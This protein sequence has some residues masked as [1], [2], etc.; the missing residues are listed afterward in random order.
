MKTK[1]KIVA[2]ILLAIF[3]LGAV[4]TSTYANHL[5][6]GEASTELSSINPG[7]QVVHYL[8]EKAYLNVKIVDDNRN[9]LEGHVVR[10][11]SSVNTDKI[12]VVTKGEV[13][14]A[15]GIVK[16][17]VTAGEP[18]LV[19]YSAYDLT[20]DVVLKNRAKVV[21]FN[22][23]AEIFTASKYSDFDDVSYAAL[24]NSAGPVD[25]FKFEDL[26]DEI[27]VGDEVTMKVSAYDE[28]DELVSAYEGEVRFSV[29]G[30][31]AKFADLPED[32]E[33]TTQDQGSH[34]FSLAFT[35]DQLGIYK[36]KVTDLENLAIYGEEE[37]V[38]TDSGSSGDFE[39]LDGIQLTTPI[40]GT[41]SSNVQVISGS[42]DPGIK[43][44]IFDNG[45][46]IGSVI[47]N[48]SGKFSFTT[49]L[50][51]DGEHKIYVASVNDVGTVVK[52]SKTVD[53]IIDTEAS[54]VSQVT[55]EP[56]G[57]VDPGTKMTVKVFAKEELS[58][59][60]VVVK[61][62]VYDLKRTGD[63]YQVSFNAPIEFGEYELKFVLVDELG[64][65]TEVKDVKFIKVGSLLGEKPQLLKVTG[66]VLTPGNNK[67]TLNW[68]APAPGS[69]IVKNYRVFYGTSPNQ[70]TQA[71]DTFTNAT[72]WYV[73]NLQNGTEYYFAVA[74]VDMQ[75]NV[76][77]NFDK[78][79]AA[80]P[81]PSVA[82]VPTPDIANG[83]GGSEALDEM[84]KDVSESG[85][86]MIWLLAV[87]ALGGFCYTIF[88]KEKVC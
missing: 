68:D 19:S 16:F 85:P 45:E 86:E 2:S 65:E 31:N 83:T 4:S 57:A 10:L 29:G 21:Y 27:A 46:E 54:S 88:K 41:Y 62:N 73:P 56:A 1:I 79:L 30:A 72:T 59:A 26:P 3:I 5:A 78:I 82:N 58:K 50:L 38:V 37:I 33:F 40:A 43:L 22:S 7:N 51:A 67:V 61:G 23:N 17:E 48:A 20:D 53:L 60:Q 12:K 47:T 64:N 13:T 74:A 36:L 87:S 25:H 52:T 42:A 66:L 39:L 15:S 18:G 76:S 69:P 84:K 81:S 8:N 9:V 24:G 71:V 75:G 35:F 63:S 6:H 44:K 32:Y 55:I 28:Q 14:D 70:L 11:I 80:T 49:G 34:T 77:T